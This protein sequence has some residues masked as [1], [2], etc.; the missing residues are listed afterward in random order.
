MVNFPC[1]LPA[2]VLRQRLL[3]LRVSQSPGPGS[4][5]LFGTAIVWTGRT[6]PLLK[7]SSGLP[8]RCSPAPSFS[9]TTPPSIRPR[10]CPPF[11]R[12]CSRKGTPLFPSPSSS[13]RAPAAL[14][15]PLTTPAGSVRP[16]PAHTAS[17]TPAASC[18]S[19]APLS[20]MQQGNKMRQANKCLPHFYVLSAAYRSCRG[21]IWSLSL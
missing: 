6:C 5:N 18:P 4:L 7:S 20:P 15:I 2:A 14:I 19:A 16:E 9:F 13:F 8:A 21:T 3:S 11:W 10:P 17:P 12:P 1:P